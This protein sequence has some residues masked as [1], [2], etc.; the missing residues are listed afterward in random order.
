MEDQKVDAVGPGILSR[1]NS[2]YKDLYTTS[3]GW[4]LRQE[5]GVR[6]GWEQVGKG[7]KHQGKETGLPAVNHWEPSNSL[8]PSTPGKSGSA[9][10]H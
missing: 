10:D 9:S 6:M 5:L 7:L 3:T 1:G 2:Q 4:M 8:K